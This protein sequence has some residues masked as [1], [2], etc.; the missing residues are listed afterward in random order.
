MLAGLLACCR[1]PP[2]APVAGELR[3][4][5]SAAGLAVSAAGSAARGRTRRRAGRAR[6][7]THRPGVTGRPL[8]R[9]SRESRDFP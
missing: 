3:G 2:A 5:P 9:R 6:V 8:R 1:R 7:A 4:A